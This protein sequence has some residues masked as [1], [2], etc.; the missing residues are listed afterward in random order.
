MRSFRRIAALLKI[1]SLC[2]LLLSG[3]WDRQ[4]PENI[5]FIMAVGVD[6]GPNNDYIYTFALAM[7]KTSSG[8]SGGGGGGESSQK[9]LDVYSVEGANLASALLASQS[10]V[11]RRLTL[12]HSKAFILGE[13]LA[14]QGSM[15]I[16]GEVVRNNEFRRTLNIIT[17]KGRAD[18][19]IKHIKPTMEKDINLWFELEMDPH[20]I[21]AVTPKKSRFHNFI[22]DM[23]QP[24]TGATTILSAIR[25]DIE[26]GATNLQD[27]ES[28]S[29]SNSRPPMVGDQYAGSLRRSGEIP[30]DIYGSAVYRGQK[31]IGFLSGTETKTLNM[32]RGEFE[33][34]ILE[35]HDPSDPERNISFKVNSQKKP[36]LKVKRTDDDQVRVA[37]L[38]QMEGDLISSMSNVNYTK[39]DQQKKLE[40][41]V[42]NELIKRASELL[43][44]TL[45]QWNVD[46]FHI[47]NQLR[48]SFPTLKAWYAYNWREHIKETKYELNIRFKMRRH[49][50]QV[51][52]AVEGDKMK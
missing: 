15:P 2:M 42:E 23:E 39:P 20:N 30:I 34:T 41:A 3:C 6:P 8:A 17:S 33:P 44:K 31:L 37:F 4:D 52:P 7:P 1:S 12:K 40:S 32:L 24:G 49:G 14:R 5:A 27:E 36:S 51:G 22:V 45:Y 47:G 11:A 35:F 9:I 25:P 46:C 43:D 38:L 26:K 28:S 13:G 10:Y 50:D 29:D 21:G 18:S 19:Y 16:L 48:A